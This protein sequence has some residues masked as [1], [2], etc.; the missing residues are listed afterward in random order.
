MALSRLG[1]FA[2]CIEH[3]RPSGILL[4]V[5]RIA[6]VLGM[7]GFVTAG[8]AYLLPFFSPVLP[9][10]DNSAIGLQ[11]F[12]AAL[13]ALPWEPWPWALIAVAAF[14]A[15]LTAAIAALFL[16]RRP[17]GPAS[18]A[19]LMFGLVGFVGLATAYVGSPGAPWAFGYWLAAGAFIVASVAAGYRLITALPFRTRAGIELATDEPA[20]SASQELLRR[21]SAGVK[22]LR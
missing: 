1:R 21:V 18:I 2:G 10:L 4:A 3:Q 17:T 11:V 13:Y 9:P 8:G 22:L 14:G 5:R 19:S 16:H 12:F 20:P 15:P 6:D 7:A